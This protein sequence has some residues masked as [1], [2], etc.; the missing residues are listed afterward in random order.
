M[1][2]STDPRDAEERALAQAL[3]EQTQQEETPDVSEALQKRIAAESRDS[4]VGYVVVQ[5]V[6]LGALVAAAV[7]YF[8][9]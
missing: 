5:V 2:P 1:S 9:V 4:G 7:W 8:W 6:L 3:R